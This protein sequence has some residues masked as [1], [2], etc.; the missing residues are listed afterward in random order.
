[1]RPFRDVAVGKLYVIPPNQ[2]GY[3]WEPRHVDALMADLEMA[4]SHDPPHAHY[5]GPVIVTRTT[6]NDFT[7]DD[8][9]TVA[10]YT[11]EDGQ[12]R[13]TTLLLLAAAIRRKLQTAVGDHDADV[14]ELERL[15]S[16]R[17]GGQRLPRLTNKNPL[18][19]QAYDYITTGSPALPA[20]QAAPMTRLVRVGTH[21]R[22]RVESMTTAE[23][24]IWKR[25]ITA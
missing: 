6:T 10:E 21:I 20:Q 14:V 19:Q 12:Q 5:M 13:I 8:L 24:R 17:R 1:M 18:L 9:D 2:R 4:G 7:D 25:R 3:A 16:Y 22:Q 15:L 23:L 11:L